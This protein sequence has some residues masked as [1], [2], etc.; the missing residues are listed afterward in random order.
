[1]ELQAIVSVTVHMEKSTPRFCV[2]VYISHIRVRERE[3]HL[4]FVDA[5]IWT[6]DSR[7]R[8]VHFALSGRWFNASV[9]AGTHRGRAEWERSP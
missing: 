4:I 5:D 6:N 7:S 8:M 3:D 1:V 9:D 2:A